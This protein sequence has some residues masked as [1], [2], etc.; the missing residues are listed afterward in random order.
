MTN[1]YKVKLERTTYQGQKSIE[2]TELFAVSKKDINTYRLAGFQRDSI[3]ILSASKIRARNVIE[4]DADIK[5][6]ELSLSV[7]VESHIDS[8]LEL[9]KKLTN[10]CKKLDYSDMQEKLESLGYVL[11]HSDNTYNYSSDFDNDLNYDVF[12]LGDVNDWI[13]DDNT[14]ILVRKHVG[15]DV[16]GG[17]NFKGIYSGAN[18]GLCYFLDFHVKLTTYEIDTNNDDDNF[19]GAGAAYQLLKEYT[20]KSFDVKTGKIIVSKD[21]ENYNLSYYH[22]AEGV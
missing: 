7:D 3:K 14:I 12:T 18:E 2:E 20:L 5:R 10:I 1:L 8:T 13:Y 6:N 21:G 16:R 9:N 15:L 17:Y 19:N 4:V 22:S 11:Q